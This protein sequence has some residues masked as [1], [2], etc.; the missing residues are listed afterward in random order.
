MS[1][2]CSATYYKSLGSR[3]TQLRYFTEKTD[4]FQSQRPSIQNL[5]EIRRNAVPIRLVIRDPI[6]LTKFLIRLYK[7]MG[8]VIPWPG[9]MS[10]SCTKV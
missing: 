4:M 1:F 10:Q 9:I 6:Q 8:L 3:Q 7:I 5:Y 2:N